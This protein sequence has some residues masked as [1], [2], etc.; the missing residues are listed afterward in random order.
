MCIHFKLPLRFPVCLSNSWEI[1]TTFHTGSCKKAL[2]SFHTAVANMEWGISQA[3][4]ISFHFSFFVHSNPIGKGC[5]SGGCEK[6]IY[7]L[8][9]HMNIMEKLFK[10]EYP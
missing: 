9:D 1:S 5:F 6:I 3:Y 7:L 10:Q 8:R 4:F 2:G